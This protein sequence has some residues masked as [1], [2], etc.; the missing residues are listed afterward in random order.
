MKSKVIFVGMGTIN[1]E[2]RIGKWPK[3]DF[4]TQFQQSQLDEAFQID[5]VV[6]VY[7]FFGKTL[8]ESVYFLHP[9]TESLLLLEVLFKKL[10]QF[11]EVFL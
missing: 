7:F 3:V 8:D 9:I 4:L 2:A 11:F 1:D 5:E 6:H 10:S